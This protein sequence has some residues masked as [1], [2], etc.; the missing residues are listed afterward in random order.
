LELNNAPASSF[1]IHLTK[2]NLI[3][4]QRSAKRLILTA[5]NMGASPMVWNH[6]GI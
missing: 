5:L 6:P 2:E 3:A 4:M 1:V